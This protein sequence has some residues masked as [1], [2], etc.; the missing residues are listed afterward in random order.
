V[1]LLTVAGQRLGKLITTSNNC[2]RRRLLILA[3]LK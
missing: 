3:E 1:Y 2:W